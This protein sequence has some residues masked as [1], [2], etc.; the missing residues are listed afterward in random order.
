M[1][2]ASSDGREQR[3]HLARAARDPDPEV[4]DR[5]GEVQGLDAVAKQG[6]VAL[7]GVQSPS[8]DLAQVG[9]E[10]GLEGVVASGEL[11]EAR[12]ELVV[13]EVA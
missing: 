12:E 13:G 1:Q 8:I 10:L 2:V 7:T 3:G 5:L 11:A 4:G 9:Q 6:G